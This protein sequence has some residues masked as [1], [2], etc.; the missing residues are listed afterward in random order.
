V[1]PKQSLGQV[2]N[3]NMVEVEPS[4]SCLKPRAVRSSHVVQQQIK[5][6]NAAHEFNEFGMRYDFIAK[7]AFNPGF[8]VHYILLNLTTEKFYQ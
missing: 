5:H 6:P 4:V 3:D 7:R 8:P 2:K 1:D